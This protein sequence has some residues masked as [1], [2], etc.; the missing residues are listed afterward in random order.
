[1]KS[2][3]VGLLVENKHVRKQ[4]WETGIDPLLLFYTPRQVLD[5]L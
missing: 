5:D 2:S 4:R 3:L 1:M